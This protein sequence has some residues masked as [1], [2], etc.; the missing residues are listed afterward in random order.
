MT[1]DV[2]EDEDLPCVQVVMIIM[3]Y[4]DGSLAPA[5]R[6]RLEAHLAE[7]GGCSTVLQQFRTT[8]ALT[9]RLGRDDIDRID[10]DTRA[11]LLGVFRRWTAERPPA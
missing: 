9:G 1:Q 5:D 8:V 11:D 3:D 4:L 7:C 2:P 10:P 6:T